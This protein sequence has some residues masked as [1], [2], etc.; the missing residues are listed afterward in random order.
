VPGVRIGQGEIWAGRRLL[1]G[2][3]HTPVA[4]FLAI[5]LGNLGTSLRTAQKRPASRAVHVHVPSSPCSKLHQN[6]HTSLATSADPLSP[7]HCSPYPTSV[8]LP[9]PAIFPI[10]KTPFHLRIGIRFKLV[11]VKFIPLEIRVSLLIPIP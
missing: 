1:A 10:P 8:D 3:S 11:N 4:T 6:L 9:T 2:Q 5:Y 7:D